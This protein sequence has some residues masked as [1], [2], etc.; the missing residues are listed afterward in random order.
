[1]LPHLHCDTLLSENKHVHTDRHADHDTALQ[2]RD[3]L[4]SRGGVDDDD[5]DGVRSARWFLDTCCAGVML[6]WLLRQGRTV[7]DA[8]CPGRA[9]SGR[10]I[11][12]RTRRRVGG[13]PFITIGALK[14][15]PVAGRTGQARIRRTRPA[16]V[17]ETCVNAS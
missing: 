13:G 6:S 9:G 7:T 8:G 1:M 12:G 11:S 4:A 2:S 14:A 15:R 16:R 3:E 5:D 10:A 17:V